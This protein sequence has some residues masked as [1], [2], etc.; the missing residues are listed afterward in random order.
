MIINH[1]VPAM[2][3]HRNLSINGAQGDR[4]MEKLSSGM[5]INRGADDAAG[6]A[7]SEKM[8]A[9]IRGYNMANR[10]AQDGISL[11]QTS[12]GYLQETTAALQRVRELA[13]Q[14][15]NGVY[16]PQDR[17]QIQTEVVQ[18]LKEV[19]RVAKQSEFNQKTLFLGDWKSSA[20]INNAAAP[21]S[22]NQPNAAQANPMQAGPGIRLHIGPNMDQE[23]RVFIGDMTVKGLGLVGDKAGGDATIDES[24]TNETVA[25]TTWNWM[26]GEKGI[27]NANRAI[28][29]T[30]EALAV[31]NKQRTDLGAMQ[32]RLETAVRGI[33]IASENLQSAESRI[34]DTDMAK[35]MIDFVKDNIMTQAA[36]SM[37]AQANLRPQMI[38]RILG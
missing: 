26:D 15:A 1:N 18:L 9:Q 25:S 8:R 36:T 5:R 28:G 7:V 27:M 3:A 20:A 33:E 35:Q 13:V 14:A 10:N 17:E 6:L 22:P 37:L 32:N 34:R 30:D 29:V 31:V 24:S 23:V 2:G 21:V 4:D 16:T 19:E 38:L 12:E 11:I